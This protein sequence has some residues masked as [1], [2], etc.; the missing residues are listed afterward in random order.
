MTRKLVHRQSP[1]SCKSV[2]L[3][4]LQPPLLLIPTRQGER[5]G[6]MYHQQPLLT[7]ESGLLGPGN[8]IGLM[9]FLFTVGERLG[10]ADTCHSTH[11]PIKIN[12][13]IFFFLPRR[14][15]F[16]LGVV[17]KTEEASGLLCHKQSINQRGGTL[18]G[19]LSVSRAVQYLLSALRIY[20]TP[21]SRHISYWQGVI[22]VK[23]PELTKEHMH[24]A[25]KR[26]KDRFFF[27]T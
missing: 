9:S 6:L 15:L 12:K 17:K 4:L 5:S 26:R 16:D 24:L 20:L 1:P 23:K 8:C 25:A 27:T 3:P 21:T 19:S 18:V 7:L 22:L 14:G 13:D 10:R 11:C 2:L